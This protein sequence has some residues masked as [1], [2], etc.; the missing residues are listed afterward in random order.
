MTI[1]R[2]GKRTEPSAHSTHASCGADAHSV[3]EKGKFV[4]KSIAV[5][6]LGLVATL[7]LVACGE[8]TQT[9]TSTESASTSA[10]P[11][12]SAS[13]S[14]TAPTASASQ[15][16]QVT[17]SEAPAKAEEKPADA[18]SAQDASAEKQVAEDEESKSAESKSDDA[19]KESFKETIEEAKK[20]PA[21]RKSTNA[22]G[23]VYTSSLGDEI[24]I[25]EANNG[26]DILIKKDGSWIR[27]TPE[28]SFV[29]VEANGSWH[30]IT[31]NGR[32]I[33]VDSDGVTKIIDFDNEIN[34]ES[35]ASLELPQTPA[36]VESLNV[37]P[38]EPAKPTKMA[39]SWG[40]E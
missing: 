31:A 23:I 22:D 27:F 8:T 28:K 15:D 26:D 12:V 37:T 40:T 13:V 30:V 16:S 17:S 36:P 21:A 9:T 18:D 1:A 6:S 29:T 11:S 38:K 34:E 14:S 25:V 4:K 3:P 19:K 5:L 33:N 32:I 10:T 2:I 35:Y 24:A 7:G 20:S 39:H